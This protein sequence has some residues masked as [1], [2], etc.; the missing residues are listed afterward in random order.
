M[1]IVSLWE[2]IS[3]RK[4]QA[5]TLKQIMICLNAIMASVHALLFCLFLYFKVYMMAAVNVV[6]VSGYLLCLL[7]LFLGKSPFGAFNYCYAEVVVHAMFA[8]IAVGTEPGFVLYLLCT[9]PLAYYANYAFQTDERKVNPIIYVIITM[10]GF[11]I[12]K[13]ITWKYDPIYV[14]GDEVVQNV[15]YTFNYIL[16]VVT[17]V[18]FMSTFLIQIRTLEDQMIK[19]NK[20]LEVMSMQDSLTGLATRRCVSDRYAKLAAQKESYAIILGDIDDFKKINDTYG[21]ACGDLVLK[22]VADLFK[23][24]VRTE[25]DIVCRWG[26]EEILVMLPGCDRGAAAQIAERIAD[27]I[28]KRSIINSDGSRILVTMTFGVADSAEGDDIKDVTKNADERLYS[29]KANGKNQVVS[30]IK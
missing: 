2:Y 7:G 3:C 20:K 4:K 16:V 5:L 12:S 8:T 21:H 17:I 13:Y 18:A 30:E 9:M 10:V 25:E 14:M 6:S 29:G 11:L 24:Y 19:K 1:F 26:G 28:R 15:I 22:T 23:E 27:G